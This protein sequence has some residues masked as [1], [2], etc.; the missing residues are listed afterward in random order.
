MNTK[1]TT[2]AFDSVYDQ[3]SNGTMGNSNSNNNNHGTMGNSNSM[4][5]TGDTNSSTNSSNI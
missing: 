1:S 3:I 5:P 2:D 4:P